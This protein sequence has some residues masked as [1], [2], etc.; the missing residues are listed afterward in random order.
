MAGGRREKNPAPNGQRSRVTPPGRP[1]RPP[2]SLISEGQ[3]LLLLVPDSGGEVARRVGVSRNTVACWRS[4]Q[5]TPT[6]PW[7]KRLA[8]AYPEVPAKAWDLAPASRAAPEAE[9]DLD[10]DDAGA[11]DAPED[12]DGVTPVDRAKRHARRISMLR[13]DAEARGAKPSTIHRLLDLERKAILDWGS[14]AGEFAPIGENGLTET[15]RWLQIRACILAALDPHP[16]CRAR[17][18]AAFEKLGA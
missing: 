17:V 7:R 2:E 9:D 11:D 13:R 15:S 5:K 18:L 4:G 12:M 1:V 3:R 8:R 10:D 14:A 16:E 6:A